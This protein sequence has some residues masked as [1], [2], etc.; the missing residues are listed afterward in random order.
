MDKITLPVN[1][2]VIIQDEYFNFCGIPTRKVTYN[3]VPQGYSVIIYM[4]IVYAIDENPYIY[5]VT[6]TEAFF[7][8]LKRDQVQYSGFSLSN[9][10]IY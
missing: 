1:T 10:E 3:S 2:K 9:F 4:S 8:S 6:L 5:S 7:S